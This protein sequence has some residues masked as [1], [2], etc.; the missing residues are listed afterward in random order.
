MDRHLSDDNSL[1]TDSETQDKHCSKSATCTTQAR[2]YI[3]VISSVPCTDSVRYP[4]TLNT[5]SCSGPLPWQISRPYFRR[6]NLILKSW[7]FHRKAK[8][9]LPITAPSRDRTS[10]SKWVPLLDLGR[11]IKAAKR[12][13]WASLFRRCTQDT[14]S[15]FRSRKTFTLTF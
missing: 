8:Y 11:I 7:K 14:S 3:T 13:G 6:S 15:A 9:N 12:R 1:V 4:V 10:G 5:S 2:K